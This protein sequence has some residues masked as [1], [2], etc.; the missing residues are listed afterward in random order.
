MI[1]TFFWSRIKSFL[2]PSIL[3]FA[4]KAKLISSTSTE[5]F[6]IGSLCCRAELNQTKPFFTLS[7]RWSQLVPQLTHFYSCKRWNWHLS[8]ILF[9]PCALFP[10]F[11]SFLFQKRAQNG[12]K[13]RQ[14]KKIIWWAHKK[15]PTTSHAVL[16]QPFIHT[17]FLDGF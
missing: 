9:P 13:E 16:V 11:S 5:P 1:I 2:K 17:H 10:F 4:K 12:L 15:S 7:K 8:K 14:K 3:K 6:S